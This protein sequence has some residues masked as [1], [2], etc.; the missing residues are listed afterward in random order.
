MIIIDD[1]LYGLLTYITYSIDEI[2]HKSII[3]FELVILGLKVI[4][5]CVGL[6]FTTLMCEIIVLPFK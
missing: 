2:I 3:R 6:I 4:N 5:R 1:F